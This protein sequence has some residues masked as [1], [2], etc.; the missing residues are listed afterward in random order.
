M[1]RQ[2]RD[3]EWRTHI[4]GDARERVEESAGDAACLHDPPQP[5]R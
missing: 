4:D 2:E 5:A 3:R 1:F